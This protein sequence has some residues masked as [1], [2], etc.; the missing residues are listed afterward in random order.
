MTVASRTTRCDR[1]AHAVSKPAHTVNHPA[2]TVSHPAHTVSRPAH[3]VSHPACTVS[4][5]A[6]TVSRPAHT[7]SRPAC[8]VSH[9]AYTVSHPAHTV[10]HP[11]HT[12]SH[13]AH[14]VSHPAHTVSHSAHTVSHPAH[15]VSHH[16]QPALLRTTAGR[17]NWL[18]GD[19][20][21]GKNVRGVAVRSMKA[22]GTA[23]DDTVR[24]KDPQP[25]HMKLRQR[26]DDNGGAHRAAERQDDLL[27][28]RSKA[29]HHPDA[30]LLPASH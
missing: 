27:N 3:T 28:F 14:T 1:A 13:P 17:S 25:A 6:C 30:S 18:I 29:K 10:S 8:T 7:V 5:P 2:H 23:Y 22:P 21:L 4:S 20:L 11:A 16:G 15:T 12:V 26:A 24:G 19:G 9:P